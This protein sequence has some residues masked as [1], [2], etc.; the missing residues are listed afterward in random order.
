MSRTVTGLRRLVFRAPNVLF[1]RGLGGVVPTRFLYLEHI[2]RRSGRLRNTVLEV[3]AH[4]AETGTFHVAAGFG[5]DSDWYRN[6]SRTPEMTIQ[7]RRSRIPARA[8][9]LDPEESGEAMVA[10]AR[11]YP[12]AARRIMSIVGADTDGTD[13]S[14]REIGRRRI[15]FVRFDPR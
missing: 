2:G 3:V 12:R 10:Y 11:R 15:P 14:Y 5:A 7:V 9:P 1:R 13:E 4:D 6:V 8:V